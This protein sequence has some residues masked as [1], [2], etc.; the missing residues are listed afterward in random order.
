MSIA[1]KHKFD[2]QTPPQVCK[3]MASLIPEGT[4]TILEPTPGI[5][6]IVRELSAY[7]VTAPDNFFTMERQRFDCVVTNPPFSAKYAHGVP[8]NM[9][10]DG[11]RLG[12]SIL[13][14]CLKMSDNV[15]ALMLWFTLSDSDVRLRS[16]K[17]WGMISVTALPR[18]TFQYAR[19]QTVVIQMQRGWEAETIFKVYDL[20]E[21]DIQHNLFD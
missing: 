18:K 10:K 4:K 2:F 11:M 13:K 14:E 16:L 21:K 20:L 8:D 7:E 17:N 12:Y 5:G 3:Y 9:L 6:N 15:I 19:I 1:E